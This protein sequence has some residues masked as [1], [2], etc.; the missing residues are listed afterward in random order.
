MT[1]PTVVVAG[2]GH[3]MRR[4]DGVGPLVADRVVAAS[5]AVRTRPP[6]ADPLDLLGWWDGADLAVVVDAV[7]SG[8][9][10]GTVVA[11]ELGDPRPDG[12]P[13]AGDAGAGSGRAVTSTHGIGLVDALRLARALGR[14]PARVVL[15][16][17]EG[18]DFGWGE[19]LSPAVAAA[20][21]GATARVL[22]LVEEVS[23][24]A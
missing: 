18:E 6:V 4:D 9:A 10:A 13:A 11:V 22:A 24:C 21:P 5:A 16:S 1:G 12:A 2:V 20:V 17:V 14:A 19:G 23:P 7:R 15:V 3:P 8:A